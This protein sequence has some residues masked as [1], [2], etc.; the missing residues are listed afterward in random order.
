MT[1]SIARAPEAAMLDLTA[2][3]L[4]AVEAP[5]APAEQ[6]GAPAEITLAARE[7]APAA[8]LTA[9]LLE[10]FGLRKWA[11][12]FRAGRLAAAGEPARAPLRPVSSR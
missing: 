12:G 10:A 7:P 4:T 2:R 3:A 11:E 8:D 9:E 5:P 1:E 6:R